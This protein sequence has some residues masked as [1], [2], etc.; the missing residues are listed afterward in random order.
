MIKHFLM[1]TLAASALFVPLMES[2]A[3]ARSVTASTGQARVG[4]Q[5]SCFTYSF[6]TGAVTSTCSTDFIVPLTTDA[7]G[8]KSLTFT[9]RA[10]AAGASCRAVANNRFG[11]SFSGS[12]F[13]SVPVNANFVS[14][15][16]GSVFVPG[17]G[18]FFADCITNSGTSLNEFD[19]AP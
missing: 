19:Y 18:V 9:S 12:A 14:Q 13:L 16:T 3:V 5:A 4:S 1:S 6:T 11:T 17:L 8:N 15:T 10:T 7:S 2:D